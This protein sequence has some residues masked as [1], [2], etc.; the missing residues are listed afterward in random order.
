MLKLK[1]K[2]TMTVERWFL[3]RG[4]AS[5][6]SD[7]NHRTKPANRAAPMLIAL[8]LVS[9]IAVA[10]CGRSHTLVNLL[11]GCVAILLTWVVANVVR[12]SPPFSGIER[13]GRM[14]CAVFVL[15]PTISAAVQ[16]YEKVDLG[17]AVLDQLDLR[18]SLAALFFVTMSLVLAVVLFTVRFG[19]VALV[20]WL[21]RQIVGSISVAGAALSRTL[22]LLMGVVLFVFLSNEVWQ[23][24]GRLDSWAYL[25]ALSLFVL[26][27]ALFLSSRQQ[28]DLAG[29]SRFEDCDELAKQLANTPLAGQ[30][31]GI[32][33]PAQTPLSRAQIFNLKLVAILARLTVASVVSV[34]VFLFFTGFGFMVVT[35]NLVASWVEGQ[36]EV[37]WTLTTKLHTYQLTWEHLRVSTFLAVFSGFYF[38]VVSATD[39]ALREGMSDT[40]SD[41]VRQACAVRLAVMQGLQD[42]VAKE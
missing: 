3:R 12:R 42:P 33:L 23:T 11:I 13:I 35:G 4:L 18:V 14:E 2:R 40:S 16:A 31:S 21:S 9:M 38:S 34:A 36:P 20:G 1:W 15:L 30:A 5:L 22:P 32:T 37:I 8:L 29:L 10:A 17:F 28:L 26:L 7:T 19:I 25:G 39:P 24:L 27:S 41:A 6:L